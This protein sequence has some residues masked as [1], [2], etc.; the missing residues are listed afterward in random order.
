MTLH[1]GIIRLCAD[2][3]SIAIRICNDVP[4]DSDCTVFVDDDGGVFYTLT[5]DQRL[6]N[7]RA[8]YAFPGWTAA[9]LAQA[10][11]ASVRQRGL[12]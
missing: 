9:D 6:A 7:W 3:P 2:I 11:L 10:L 1:A 8:Y 12:V 4:A 5:A